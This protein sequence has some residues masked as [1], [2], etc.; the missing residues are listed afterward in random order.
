MG[1]EKTPKAI[2][3]LDAMYPL[4]AR[5]DA[6]YRKS[7]EAMAEG[8]PTVWSM[9]NWWQGAPVLKAMDVEVV[10]PENY[11]AV[12][13]ATGVA[14]TY[15]ERS[16]AAGF[17]THLCG[18]SRNNYGY[19]HRMIRELGG[20]IP[21]EAPMGGMPPPVLLL[22]SNV[23]C[24]ARYK[25]FQGLGRYLD[26]PVYTLEMPIP[27]VKELFHEGI[28]ESCVKL[29]SENVR[30]FIRF[31]ERLLRQRLDWDRLAQVVDD[32]LEMNRVWYEV[33]EL[34][35][36]RPCPMHSRHFWSCM[37]AS[38]YLLGDT[39]SAVAEYTALRDEL[40]ALIAAGEG[41]IP[42]EKYRLAFGELP[43]WHSL[44]FFEILAGRGWN[45]VV[46]SWVYH[47]PIPLD[48]SGVSDPGEKIARQALQFNTGFYRPAAEARNDFGYMGYPYVHWASEYRIDGMFMHPLV[49]CRSASTHL[50]FVRE[51]LETQV[52]VPSLWVEGDIVDFTLFDPDEA[53]RR[54]EAFEESMEHHREKRA[55]AGLAW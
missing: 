26:A 47:P 52:S 45:F 38:L 19:T 1:P 14:P 32:M 21:P 22:A 54:A 8:R 12:C 40:A 50:G 23:I 11:G 27:G 34:R 16:D 43:P 46:E 5:V 25:W 15:L 7:V 20:R 49:T 36:A 53:L 24:D 10:Y 41:A 2:R 17:P 6:S 3:S 42:R 33:N 30:E 55:E 18:Y 35:K 48:L 37:P 13:A 9:A 28:Y 31:A 29:V 4:R 44:G 39:K 51:C